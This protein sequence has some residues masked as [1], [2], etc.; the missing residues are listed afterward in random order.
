[1]TPLDF[2]FKNDIFAKNAGIILLEDAK[3]YSKPNW[4]IKAETS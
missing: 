3:G 2:F 1:M 4:K